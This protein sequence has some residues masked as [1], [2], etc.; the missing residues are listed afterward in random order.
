MTGSMDDPKIKYDKKGLKQKI[1]EDL[2]QEKQTIKELLK[3]E[4]G[5]FKKD[6]LSKKPANKAEQK[7]ELEKPDNKSAKKALEVKKKKDDDDDF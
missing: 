4:F 5:L 3:A 2:K 7:F 1:K 6:S